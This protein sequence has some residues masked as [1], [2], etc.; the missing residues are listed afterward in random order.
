MIWYAGVFLW[1]DLD[2]DFWLV[3]FLWWSVFRLGLRAVSFFR[4]SSGTLASLPLPNPSSFTFLVCIILPSLCARDLRKKV[5]CPQSIS[6]SVGYR[7]HSSRLHRRSLDSSRKDRLRRRLNPI[8]QSW[9]D[10]KGLIYLGQRNVFRTV[11][12]RRVVS[13]IQKVS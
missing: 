6:R 8:S 9:H 12:L 5:N 7:I 3:T 2:Q 13:C 1:V 11:Y 4:L 10:G